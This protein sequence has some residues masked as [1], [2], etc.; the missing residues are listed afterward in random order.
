MN[1][2]LIS[3]IFINGVIG[4]GVCHIMASAYGLYIHK[5]RENYQIMLKKTH[6]TFCMHT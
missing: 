5:I 6:E 2:S 4:P 1:L 3:F